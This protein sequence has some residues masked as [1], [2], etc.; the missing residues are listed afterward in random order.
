ML[1][2]ESE[3]IR[4]MKVVLYPPTKDHW[5]RQLVGDFPQLHWRVTLSA[6]EAGRE[7]RDAD[8]M[9]LTN[10]AC[11]R[12]LG[13]A[14]R[15]NA[16][17]DL[18]WMHFTTAGIDGG[19]AMGL[20]DGVTVTNA[21]GVKAGM[22]SEHALALLLALLRRVPDI[23]AGQRVRKW[24]RDEI[25]DKM[26]TLEGATVCIVGLG[27]I[28]REVARKV[29]AFDAKPI[30]VSRAATNAGAVETV[31]PRERLGEAL[32]VSD[33]VV[34]CTN[35]DDST[36]H[37]I[38]ARE[39]AAMKPGAILVNV[40]RGTL[41]D[42]AALIDAVRKGALGGAALDVQAV[43]PLPEDSPLWNLP[44]VI[45]SPHSAGSGSTG[46]LQHRALFA[47]NLERY[48]TGKPLLNQCRITA[49]A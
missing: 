25:S 17:P 16:G 3:E 29:K 41:I 42:E 47:Q 49:Q 36:R 24:R 45:V 26:G 5:L 35:A 21:A 23:A 2:A 7:V 30:A 18:K 34:I 37:M 6:D 38:G 28:G 12:E 9:V 48:R 4:S 19:I 43:E 10:R 15:D 39:L 44:N 11:S 40:A 20:P 33:V 27:A 46:Y 31:Y 22:V 1:A 8:L 13:A 32:A 14:L